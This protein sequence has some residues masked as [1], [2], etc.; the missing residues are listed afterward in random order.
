MVFSGEFESV[1][2]ELRGILGEALVSMRLFT[3]DGVILY[4]D[5]RGS[6][7]EDFI[8]ASCSAISEISRN[9]SAQL[10]LEGEPTIILTLED[11]FI[12]IRRVQRDAVIMM[13]VRGSY[14]QLSGEV[15]EA[16][17]RV[18]EFLR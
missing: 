11:A 5:S 18:G 1:V 17:R 6:A 9:L 2:N 10:G 15:A 12:V 4:S 16:L 7:A 13:G 14:A 8:V 3:T